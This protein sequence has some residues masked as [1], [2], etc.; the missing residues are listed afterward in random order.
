MGKMGRKKRRKVLPL[1]VFPAMGVMLSEKMGRRERGR[2]SGAREKEER[3][4]LALPRC[5][6]LQRREG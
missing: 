6:C 4:P 5:R 3:D 1:A 2:E